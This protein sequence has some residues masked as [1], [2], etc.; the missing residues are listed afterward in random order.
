M[1]PLPNWPVVAVTMGNYST[2]S[3]N[4]LWEESIIRQLVITC[5]MTV[6]FGDVSAGS[7]KNQRDKVNKCGDCG[8]T[9]T[10]SIK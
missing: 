7:E 6:L 5:I 1:T 2:K 9:G 4:R 10:P 3:G 8:F